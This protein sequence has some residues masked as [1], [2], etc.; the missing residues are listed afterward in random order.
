M[1]RDVLVDFH[2]QLRTWFLD[3]FENPTQVQ[4]ASWPRIR[5]GENLLITAPTGS[6]K[7]LTAFLSAIDAII[8]RELPLGRTT[9]LYVS[10]L[11][12]LNNDIKRNLAGPLTDLQQRFEA[13]NE[14]W[15]N[16]RTA[17]RSG[18]SSSTERQRMLRHRPEIVITTPES[19]SL[20]L[21]AKSGKRLLSTV[22]V[23]IL[24][25]IHAV[26]DSRR[27][28]HLMVSLE[29]LVEL[30]GEFQRIALSA[31]VNPLDRVAQYVGGYGV[32]GQAREVGIVKTSIEKTIDLRVR[33]PPEARELANAS[34]SIWPALIDEFHKHLRANQSTLIFCAS[35]RQSERMTYLLNDQAQSVVAY[36]H[37]GSLSRE[38]RSEVEVRLKAGE[39]KA[40]AATSSLELGI[41]I[42]ELDEVLLVQSPD[43]VASAMQ[44]IGR[45]GH[46]VGE[47]SRATFY[48]LF[49]RDFLDAAVL[50]KAV[51]EAD[52]EPAKILEEPLDLL[53]QTLVAMVAQE[54]WHVDDAFKV[55]TRAAP[56]HELSRR[57]FD[58]VVEMLT[59][60]YERSRIRDLKP[61]VAVDDETQILS[62]R[63]GAALALYAN[64]GT[65]PDRGYF[66]MK[67]AD[68][69]VLIGELD[70]E[71]VWET[72]VGKQFV[73][74]SQQWL[75]TDITHNDVLVR[76]ASAKERVPP[77][78]RSEFI[79]KSF[80]F[81]R[82]IGT[83]LE[84]ANNLLAN[85]QD[86]LLRNELQN[87]GFEVEAAEELIRYLSEQRAVTGC[88]LPHANHV[89]AELVAA[90]PGGYT[91]T[92]N[93][94][95]L[96]LHTGWGGAVNR[97][98]ALCLEAAWEE[99]FAT[100][101]DISVDNHVIGI[102]M[103]QDVSVLEILAMLSPDDLLPKIRRALEKSG[104]FGARFREC[105]G[106]ALLLSKQ[107]FDRRMPLWL[108]RMQAKDLLSSV[109]TYEDFPI[110]LETWRSCLR[111]EFDIDSTRRVLD[112]LESGKIEISECRTEVASP[113]GSTIA[114]NQLKRYVYAD[115]KPEGGGRV[116]SLS[117]ELIAH[118]L[119]D[120]ALRPALS[121]HVVA[122]VERKL[123][124][125]E[126]GYAPSTD[127]ELL[128]WVKERV[129]V[130]ASEWFENTEVPAQLLSLTKD[131]G[132]WFV[133]QSSA[134]LGK[135]DAAITA[136][137]NAMQFYGPHTRAEWLRLIPLDNDVVANALED[138]VATGT[139]VAD[140]AVESCGELCICDAHNLSTLL[141]FQRLHNRPIVEA[142]PI[143]AL[144]S[145]LSTWHRFDR[146]HA[147][148]AML[149]VLARMQGF[150]APVGVWL[151]EI[152]RPRIGVNDI[153]QLSTVCE[154]YAVS[155]RG[156][157]MQRIALGTEGE[158]GESADIKSDVAPI[159]EAF[160]DPFGSYTYLQLMSVTGFASGDFNERFWTAVWRGLITS[161]A[162]TAL[163]QAHAAGYDAQNLI[164]TSL[165]HTRIRFGKRE[166]TQRVL[167]MWRRVHPELASHNEIDRLEDAKERVRVLAGRYGVLCRELCN[168]EGRQYRWSQLFRALRMMELSGELVSGLFFDELSG[169]QFMQPNALQM[170]IGFANPDHAFWINSY[171]PV[172]PCGLGLKWAGLPT[173]QVGNML[174]F[175]SGELTAVSRTYG[176]SL[177]FLVEPDDQRV[178]DVCRT[179]H[180]AIALRKRLTIQTINGQRSMESP[181]LPVLGR[182][183]QIHRGV[184]D[185]HID[186]IVR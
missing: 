11:K 47:V 160:T 12:A 17:V 97:P 110:L 6:G 155:W 107:R 13:A 67:H 71:F 132:K 44:R 115:D 165:H 62:I 173:R 164:P 10:P 75:V 143:Q 26:L 134:K 35:R 120:A 18:D 154:Q 175:A 43:S 89:V 73:F 58:L 135:T 103:K 69:N 125:R 121:A 22:Q 170:F 168:R 119:R 185:V 92:G 9:V 30:A 37:H 40:I 101:P 114:H 77:F 141:R 51:T 91:S 49:A 178:D 82:Q 14:S 5:A 133:H 146:E 181:Y 70:E 166:R 182:H 96:I 144:P 139:L 177:D 84:F 171:D 3:S 111:D 94:H 27:G 55:I 148:D 183:M 68:S 15:P 2:P 179:M 161:N 108:T 137:A 140:V 80:Y 19:L 48:P 38:V 1:S 66:K 72:Q 180:R 63:K 99:R 124:R 169:P 57:L 186:A 28:V 52:I 158:L 151:N 29:R 85:D 88:D 98:I 127:A 129:W 116:S 32:N 176:K 118:A 50:A 105:A 122:Q 138:L 136:I 79:N 147:A 25:E 174:A 81:S 41:D 24:D 21:T 8:K 100:V 39:L 95:Q 184:R 54:D 64:G 156:Y 157:G 87:R 128:E 36:A 93:A 153:T 86:Y 130:Q 59:G 34:E 131:F 152:W 162:I 76:A 16:I 145:F 4:N 65:I 33:F 20:L 83:F 102:Q 90:G 106:R 150:V 142:K 126:P 113:F 7:T 159:I 172:S 163:A 149:D 78:Y 123:Q 45:A 117:D 61:R 56:Y 60:K 109:S 104:F 31:T 53:A 46:K 74:G 167:G 42:G 112:D 23:V